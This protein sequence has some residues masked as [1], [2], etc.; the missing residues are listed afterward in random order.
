VLTPQL[1]KDSDPE[2]TAAL[3]AVATVCQAD[4]EVGASVLLQEG[5][6]DEL[7]DS[8]DIDG[9][10]VRRGGGG[11]GARLAG[12]N[13]CV[14]GYVCGPMCDAS[15]FL[16]VSVSV[17]LGGRAGTVLTDQG[18]ADGGAGASVCGQDGTLRS[19]PQGPRD[20]AHRPPCQRPTVRLAAFRTTH[21]FALSL[22]YRTTRVHPH[23]LC[24][25]CVCVCVCACG[26]GA[27]LHATRG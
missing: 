21:S 10:E 16:S 4:P 23:S 13:L 18:G 20:P 11:H 12:P 14:H 22:L 2:R 8:Y 3:V 1:E 24:S 15:L 5:V 27:R 9:H 17:R 25:V 6:L 26:G 7:L 19:R